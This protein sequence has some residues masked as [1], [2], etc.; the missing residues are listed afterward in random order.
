MVIGAGP[1]G[2]AAA[3]GLRQAGLRVTLVEQSA[4]A[5]DRFCGEFLS[6]EAAEALRDLGGLETLYS[7]NPVRVRRMALYS[8][9]GSL[10][11]M[12][13]ATEGFGVA[14]PRLDAALLD[15]VRDRGAEH[16]SGVKIS[17]IDGNS[18]DGFVL[19][20]Q[21]GLELRSRAVIGA[22][23][24][25]SSLDR[26]L[27]RSFLSKTTGFVGV[28]ARF[29]GVACS[30]NVNLFSFRGGHCGLVSIE[31]DLATI[32]ILA[33]QHTLREVGGKPRALIDYARES[34][35]ALKAEL[36]GCELVDGSL[37]TIAQ[38]P[39]MR[40]EPVRKDVVFVGDCAGITAPFLG[41]GV[42]NAFR[43]GA[44]AAECLSEWL[45][46]AAKPEQALDSYRS[47]WALEIGQVQRWSFLLSRGLCSPAATGPAVGLLKMAPSMGRLL[48]RWS[49]PNGHAVP[50]PCVNGVSSPGSYSGPPA[51]PDG[52]ERR[53]PL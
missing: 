37:N 11:E 38:V 40:K 25:R 18:A 9:G 23:G 32:G 41:V 46:Q 29:R 45:A 3:L 6:G 43:S 36:D 2:C 35:L 1:A 53:R 21:G 28:K 10:Y 31:P 17:S 49:R 33:R 47:R 48:Y 51:D 14:R 12:P 50:A 15:L 13:L 39:L 34:N 42:T 16:L 8:P 22:W 19:R 24:K 7:L 27:G 44:V 52:L 5:P 4:R 30:E 20:A 26:M